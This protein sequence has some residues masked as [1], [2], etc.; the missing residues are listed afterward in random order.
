M[1]EF[2][3]TNWMRQ[4]K[5]GPYGKVLKESGHGDAPFDF[6]KAAIESATGDKISHTELDDYDR[7]IYWSTKNPNVTYYISD[8]DQIIKY[9]GETGERYPVGDL[10]QYDEP[11]HDYEPDTDADY[12]EP[13]EDW[14][15]AGDYNDGEFWEGSEVLKEQGGDN[16][17]TTEVKVDVV[18]DEG[19]VYEGK[20]LEYR[21]YSNATTMK[22]NY[23]ID[24]ELRSWGLKGVAVYAPSGEST[25]E[26]EV[27]VAGEDG[28]TDFIPFKGTIDW[29][30]VE[31]ENESGQDT[32]TISPDTMELQF[33]K[34]CKFV[35]GTVMY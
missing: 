8:D 5:V 30:K 2:N 4:N 24:F 12:E 22:I 6:N 29:S 14:P 20:E 7:T 13:R 9:D 35:Q 18:F 3:Y 17:F 19:A 15:M 32:Y 16:K 21:F 28:E 1:N 34:D 33:D 10:K 25:I 26:F 27:E 31:I 11:T 23:L